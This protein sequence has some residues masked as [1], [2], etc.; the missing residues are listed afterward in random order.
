MSP[1]SHLGGREF[2]ARPL[3][4]GLGVDNVARAQV[5]SEQFSFPLSVSFH[6][7]SISINSSITDAMHSQLKV[8]I[9][10]EYNFDFDT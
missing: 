1:D 10:Q 6:H 2:S 9:C 7:C 4:I 3:S 5:F 8:A